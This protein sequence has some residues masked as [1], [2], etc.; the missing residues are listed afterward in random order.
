MVG[1][2][3]T[4]LPR[5]LTHPLMGRSA[6]AFRAVSLHDGEVGVPARAPARLT[7]VDFWASFCAPC[8]AGLPH[9]DAVYRRH[10]RDGVRL[11]AVSVDDSVE[12]AAQTLERLRIRP[13]A[14]V[15]SDHRIVD[16]YGVRQIPITF[17]IDDAARVRWVGHDPSAAEAAVDALLKERP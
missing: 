17:I 1:C 5:S 4:A 12:E 16:L 10:R 6:P 3:A 8:Q 13:P 2:G 14:V 7:I 15:D 11:I 9:L